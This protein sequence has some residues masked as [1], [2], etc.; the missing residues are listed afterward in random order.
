MQKVLLQGQ[1]QGNVYCEPDTS[2]SVHKGVI[3][4]F[5]R[6]MYKKCMLERR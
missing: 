1:G 3:L 5:Y 6:F 4:M 2:L